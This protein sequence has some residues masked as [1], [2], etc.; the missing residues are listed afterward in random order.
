MG[1]ILQNRVFAIT[2]AVLVLVGGALYGVNRSVGRQAEKLSAKYRDGVY[3]KDGDYVATSMAE[4][5][6]ESEKAA[7]RLVTI[8][9]KYDE[10][11]EQSHNLKAARDGIFSDMGSAFSRKADLDKMFE[12]FDELRGKAEGVA[13]SESDKSAYDDYVAKIT[14]ARGAM[15]TNPYNAEAEK[16]Q[17]QLR[18]FPVNI[19]NV[20]GREF[21]P[22]RYDI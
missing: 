15:R 20:F 5:L 1:N 17:K 16:L 10:L 12:A 4:L 22:E 14:G 18:A 8:T 3:V 7:M 2:V 9:E 13:M 21:I 19:L 11:K 6:S